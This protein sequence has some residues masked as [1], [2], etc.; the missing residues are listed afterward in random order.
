MA[1]QQE[2][3]LNDFLVDIFHRI[4]RI[5]EKALQEEPFNNLTIGEMHAI[6]AIGR[7]ENLQMSQLATKLGITVGTFSITINNLVKKGYVER[8]RS[9]DDRR[10]VYI[11]LTDQGQKAHAHHQAFHH[12]M[13]QA[14]TSEL[15]Q[16]SMTL[17]VNAL[18]KVNVY[19]EK[20]YPL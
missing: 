14:I 11:K 19:F 3:F 10:V 5:E 9:E 8:L 13:I 17:L 6:E 18:S 7:S 4:L 12:E 1:N 2:K 16:E 15:D 20:K